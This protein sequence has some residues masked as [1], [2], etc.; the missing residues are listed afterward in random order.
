[1]LN[2]SL[3]LFANRRFMCLDC[4]EQLCA[5]CARA[6]RRQTLS[7]SHI[8]TALTGPSSGGQLE[9]RQGSLTAG[10]QDLIIGQLSVCT[11]HPNEK[12]HF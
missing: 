1:M 4:N 6:H 12:V 9:G 3:L 11:L 10:L 7:K 2:C 5:D 8:V